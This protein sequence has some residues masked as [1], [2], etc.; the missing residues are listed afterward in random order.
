MHTRVVIIGNGVAGNTAALRLRAKQ[1]HWKITVVSGESKYHY[2]RPALMYVFMG[3]MRYR[4]TKPFED[5]YWDKQRIELMR[6]WVTRIDV[7]KKRLELHGGAALSFDKLL[8]ATGSKPNK[9]GWPG[10][11]LEGVQGLWGLYD[12]DRLH[13][14][15]ARME[16][17]VLVGGGLIGVEL[18]EML[19][20][21][22]VPVTFLVREKAYWNSV[23]PTEESAMVTREVRSHGV[24]L[25]L[26]TELD[27]ILG[28]SDG[29]CRGVVTKDGETIEC[30]FVGLTAGVRPN[31]GVV[32]NSP[33][34]TAR[35]VLVD[36]GLATNITDIYAAGD[37]AE[38]QRPEGQRNV[39]QQVWYTGKQQGEV[40]GDVLAGEER[41]HEPGIFFNSAKFFELEY[42]IYGQVGMNVT[43]EENLYWESPSAAQ[44]LRIVHANGCVVGLN[45]MGWRFRH[46][47]C[48]R[49]IAERREPRYVIEHLG[50][51][52]FDPE[53]YRR[54]ESAARAS[55][56]EQLA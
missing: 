44:A 43:G 23:L 33:I 21:R 52:H 28:D 7:D 15:I 19:L 16:R 24:D 45:L 56:L 32:E 10:Q 49:W 22:G 25:R 1:P 26:E 34:E 27:E 5:S 48:E 11:D 46:E 14:T 9:F 47:V 18:A 12:L 17:A 54:H 3:H 41:R 38:T 4:D 50:D 2:S 20:S 35:G 39:L 6:A 31:I 55:L 51:A 30:Q 53:F 8:I 29:R 40:A 42:Q 36:D 37:C 13:K